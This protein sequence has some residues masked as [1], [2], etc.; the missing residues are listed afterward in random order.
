MLSHVPFFVLLVVVVVFL[1]LMNSPRA[2]LLGPLVAPL[3]V[4]LLSSQAA[5]DERRR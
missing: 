4:A 5:L 2:D 1:S 3:F